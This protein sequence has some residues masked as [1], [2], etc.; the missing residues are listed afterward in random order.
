MSLQEVTIISSPITTRYVQPGSTGQIDL[1]TN[2]IR[3]GG[4]WFDYDVK[5]WK[6]VTDENK[7]VSFIKD[8]TNL[9]SFIT[10][11]EFVNLVEAYHITEELA[12]DWMVE[13]GK[14]HRNELKR[15]WYKDE[16]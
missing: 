1:V 12:M 5:R 11:N 14:F 6:V 2:K 9:S 10:D 15:G 3:A 4:V 8:L 16:D 13:N 7:K